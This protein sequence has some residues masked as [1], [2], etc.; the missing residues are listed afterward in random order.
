MKSSIS[1]LQTVMSLKDPE[2]MLHP[3]MSDRD[4]FHRQVLLLRSL[5]LLQSAHIQ[6]RTVMYSFSIK[7]SLVWNALSM[8]ETQVES[9]Y[10]SLQSAHLLFLLVW[11]KCTCRRLPL[12]SSCKLG[13]VICIYIYILVFHSR[14]FIFVLEVTIPGSETVVQFK[15]A[16]P[17]PSRT[18]ALG[19]W[20]AWN[21]LHQ[22]ACQFEHCYR[23][24]NQCKCPY[25]GRS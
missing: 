9:M 11:I 25:F 18:V 24:N 17:S 22:K 10:G 2:P 15:W 16:V 3:A 5:W 6:W 14:L 19:A 12:K 20:L 1:Y 7:R 21:G 4:Y 8:F 23:S 13:E